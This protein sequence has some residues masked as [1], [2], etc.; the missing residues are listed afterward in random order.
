MSKKAP[1]RK[2]TGRPTSYTEER[3]RAL[4]GL[5][6]SG[7][8]TRKACT[9]PGMPSGPTVLRWLN[10][11]EDFRMQYARAKSQAAE[12]Q[13]E[14]IIEIADT[15][16]DVNRARV[17]IDARKWVASKLVP[18]KYGERMAIEGADGQPLV[19]PVIRVE[20][21]NAPQDISPPDV[22]E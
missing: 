5:V 22:D 19:P 8:S 3:G 21:V 14:E 7:M 1:D 15:E 13:A 12:R 20:I 18:K 4:C 11:Y 2:R 6:A 9:K 10:D 16:P 17:R